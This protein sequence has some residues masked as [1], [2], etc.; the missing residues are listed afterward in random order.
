[1]P[2]KDIGA[3]YITIDNQIFFYQNIHISYWEVKHRSSNFQK[4]SLIPS[5]KTYQEH[6]FEIE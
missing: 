5:L 3:P 6:L 4:K 2:K 1:V